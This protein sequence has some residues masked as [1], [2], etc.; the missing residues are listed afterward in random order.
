MF[1]L[2][3]SDIFLQISNTSRAW[4]DLL[5][6]KHLDVEMNTAFSLLATFLVKYLTI[7]PYMYMTKNLA[8]N[9]FVPQQSYMVP[10]P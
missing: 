5:C 3:K 9:A 4:E 7:E 1:P 2:F 10:K 6:Q 8:Y